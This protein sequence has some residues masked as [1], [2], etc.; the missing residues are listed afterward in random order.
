VPKP[1]LQL[2]RIEVRIP[3]TDRRVRIIEYANQLG[4]EET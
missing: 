1:D 3:R 2:R 4:C